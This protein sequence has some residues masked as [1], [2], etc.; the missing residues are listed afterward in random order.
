MPA[1]PA[2][3]IHCGL[4][5]FG[6][7]AGQDSGDDKK[8]RYE[9]RRQVPRAAARYSAAVRGGRAL[10]LHPAGGEKIH[11]LFQGKGRLLLR[12]G[13]RHSRR[14]VG[15][16]DQAVRSKLVGRVGAPVSGGF[17][18]QGP[19]RK[20]RLQSRVGAVVF[21]RDERRGGERGGPAA[22]AD[23]GRT[24]RKQRRKQSG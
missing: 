19:E 7:A 20:R 24:D 2:C 1:K 14:S 5:P 13:G 23:A 18:A 9:R 4:C 16:T 17:T 15:G 8:Q 6:A 21:L 12:I 10:A 11:Q 3:Q 22:G